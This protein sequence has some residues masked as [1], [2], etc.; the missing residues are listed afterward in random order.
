MLVK[1]NEI[2]GQGER[3]N[4]GS[5]AVTFSWENILLLFTDTWRWDNSYK[6]AVFMS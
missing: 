1:L 2:L 5:S 3:V 6:R 4:F